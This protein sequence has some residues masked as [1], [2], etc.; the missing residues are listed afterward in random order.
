M[1]QFYLPALTNKVMVALVPMKVHRNYVS[2][3]NLKL[4]IPLT[5]HSART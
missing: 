5:Q 4:I 3:A 1:P 2:R